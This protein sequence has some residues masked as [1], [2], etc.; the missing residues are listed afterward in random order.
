M[1]EG[2]KT[3]NVQSEMCFV[4]A[5]LSNTDLYINYGNFMRSK[6][7]FS[8]PV[9][10][11]LYDNLETYYLTFSQTIDE[12]KMN[13]FMSQNDERLKTYKQYKGYKTIEQYI[14]FADVN[15]VDNY[16]TTVKKFSLLREYEK[17]GFPVDKI[18][19]HSRFDSMTASDIY[20]IIRVK[21]D[22][23]NTVISAG[24]EAVEL[25]SNNVE[26][27]NSYIDVPMMGLLTPW[28]LYNE[29][30]LGLL[31]EDIILEGF[32]SNEGK[33]RKLMLLAA[34]V[35][36]VQNKSFLFMSNE[37][38]EKKLR[39]CLI[40]TVLNNKEFKELHGVK[41]MKPEKEIKL[42]VYRDRTGDLIR[43][44]IDDDGNYTETKDEFL[45]RIQQESDEYWDV[46]KVGKW[47]DEHDNGKLLFKD[48]GD[49]YSD[50][51]IEFELRKYKTVM[52]GVYYG[53]DTL[54]GY[55]SEEWSTIKQSATRIKEIT[56]ELGLS[57][58]LVFQLT[59]DTVFTDIFSL[60]SNNIAG[61]KGIKHVTDA[62]TLGKRIPHESYYLYQVVIEND[63]WGEP[64]AKDLDYK[65]QYFAIK[66]DKNRDGDKDKIM[67][68]EIDL[69]YNIWDNVGYL[70]KKP[71]SAD[72]D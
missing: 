69:N 38:S 24:T 35:S 6:Y 13:V 49:D 61:A 5:L 29:M 14:R 19:R 41:L 10:R 43:R 50:R 7:D 39:A 23:I 9:V 65:K 1:D 67:A 40:T 62:L 26:T 15:D 4:G 36:L 28:Y 56:K 3:T 30:F 21:A 57:G 8:D 37:M 70:I 25:T 32:L 68:F 47:I 27:I 31:N 71:R 64:I 20:R 63:E 16:F 48:V 22:K 2:L 18:M 51:Q 44:K 60:S 72:E 42:G 45:K 54:K 58:F 59:D 46:I 55:R 66:A 11:F 52:N 34:Y 33:T 12:T 53:Y 17:N